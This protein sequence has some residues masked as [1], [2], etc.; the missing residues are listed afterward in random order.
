MRSSGWLRDG[1]CSL[2]GHFTTEN[3]GT[4]EH[5]EGGESGAEEEDDLQAAE[6]D[7]HGPGKAGEQGEAATAPVAGRAPQVLVPVYSF[8]RRMASP[9]NSTSMRWSFCSSRNG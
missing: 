4:E 3:G 2:H 7:A 8:W 9:S 5:Q 6:E 1:A